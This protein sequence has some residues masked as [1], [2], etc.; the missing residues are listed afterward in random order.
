[1]KLYDMDVYR[2]I[3][4]L[5]DGYFYEDQML[6]ILIN[7]IDEEELEKVVDQIIND[8]RIPGFKKDGK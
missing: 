8:Y 5:T 2:K 6:N 3:D 1:M 7:Y 4:Y